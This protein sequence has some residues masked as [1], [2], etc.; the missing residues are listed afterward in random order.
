[1]LKV[2]KYHLQGKAYICLAHVLDLGEKR[3]GELWSEYNI[4]RKI[5]NICY[6]EKYIKNKMQF[7]R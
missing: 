4:W 7:L 2:L 5:K 6:I 3:E 1:M